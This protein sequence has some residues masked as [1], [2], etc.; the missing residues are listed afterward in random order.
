MERNSSSVSL[1]IKLLQ[2]L[3]YILIGVTLFGS[4]NLVHGSNPPQ[5]S[6][7]A[8]PQSQA[9]VHV[10]KIAAD[11]DRFVTTKTSA[12]LQPLTSFLK[13]KEIAA[14]NG[15]YF[16][17]NN[18]QTTSFVTTQNKLV[19]DPRLNSR[20][21]DNPDLAIYLG[22]ILNRAEFRRYQCD[23][24]NV[25]DITPHRTSTPSDC[26]L[27]D[28]LGAG[29]QLLPADTSQAEGFTAYQDGKLVRN[30]IGVN[31]ANARSAVGITSDGTVVLAMV[32]QKNSLNSG[33]SLADLALF[34]KDLGVTKAMNLDG[35]SS[36]SL[37][38]RGRTYYGKL[39]P[40]GNQ[41]KRPLKSILVVQEN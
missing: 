41:V 30:A 38:Y 4:L 35:G 7:Q 11:S 31:T 36:T 24:H 28:A 15:G 27:L 18:Q 19:A 26:V 37:Y 12:K 6:Y 23:G 32:E 5:V 29:P 20:L 34:L 1:L 33:L 10:V 9:I 2:Y 25:Y 17:P 13:G 8:Y 16:D 3:V 14:I 21:V 39:N 22:K 40:E